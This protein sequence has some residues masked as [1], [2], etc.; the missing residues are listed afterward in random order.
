MTARLLNAFKLAWWAYR[1]PLTIQP[2]NFQMLSDILKLIL[3]VATKHRPRMTRI[4][5]VHPID[6]SEQAIVSIWAGAGVAAD[7]L[8]RIEELH[9]EIEKLNALLLIQTNQQPK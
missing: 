4:A 9:K 2:S 8:K 5:Y 7:P 6:G 1:N 3:E